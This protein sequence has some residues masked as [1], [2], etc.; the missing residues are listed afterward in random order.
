MEDKIE[1]IKLSKIIID[2]KDN[3]REDY[4][5]LT[6]LQK[7]ME[8]AGENIVP[9]LVAP[10][11]KKYKLVY[12][13]RRFKCAKNLNWA[14]IKCIVKEEDD[15]NVRFLLMYYENDSREN[16]KWHEE[17]KAL[18]LKREIDG[19]LKKEKEFVNDE[20]EERGVSPR[21]VERI[22]EGAKIIDEYPALKNEPTRGHAKEKYIRIKDLDDKTREKI[23]NEEISIDEALNRKVKKEKRET[24]DK[25][26]ALVEEFK[27]DSK[28]Y[29]TEYNKIKEE[30][31]EYKNN[32]FESVKKSLK[33]QRIEKGIWLEKEVKS[34]IDAAVTCECF[35]EKDGMD[36]DECK[37]CENTDIFDKCQFW[38]ERNKN[39]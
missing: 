17:S 24:L 16:L 36:E 4:G 7:S 28:Y 6:K 18:K 5:D 1:Y 15:P 11:K 19:R 29:E 22:L 37:K 35:G 38:Y 25:N 32:I 31:K 34:M 26:K 27:K 13:Y 20:G 14:E 33:D 10:E 12:G 21:T 23:K 30:F 9:I 2:E 3:I 8:E 39:S